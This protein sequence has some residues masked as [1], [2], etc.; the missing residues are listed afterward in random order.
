MLPF[1]PLMN[2]KLKQQRYQVKRVLTKTSK[3]LV[4]QYFRNGKRIP[5]AKGRQKWIEQNYD[6]LDKPYAQD[7]PFLSEK[8]KLSFSNAKAQRG[9]FYY[10]GKKIPKAVTEIMKLYGDLSDKDPRDI[11]K[12]KDKAG[13]QRFKNY[14]SFEQLYQEAIRKLQENPPTI[15]VE[16]KLGAKGHRGRVDHTTAVSIAE[17]LELVGQK[18]W[19]IQVIDR[20][21]VTHRGKAAAMKAVQDWELEE[22]IAKSALSKQLAML[23]FYH[24]IYY[25]YKNKRLTIDL[26]ESEAEE[27]YSP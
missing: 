18:G 20:N 27:D 24:K 11:T 13:N 15:E 19:K 3:G 6:N 12:I 7:K 5:D 1:F 9:L 17:A 22:M 2:K 21:D 4:P 16:T 8:E 26:A 25:D 23:R 14:G 10:K